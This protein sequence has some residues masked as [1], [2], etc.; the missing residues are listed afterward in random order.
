MNVRLNTFAVSED[1]MGAFVHYKEGQPEHS[2]ISFQFLFEGYI[3]GE[4][5][6]TLI[7]AVPLGRLGGSVV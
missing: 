4:I 2:G 5:F 7:K 6:C 1:Q 3:F